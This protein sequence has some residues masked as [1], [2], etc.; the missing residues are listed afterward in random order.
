MRSPPTPANEAQR[1]EALRALNILDTA[2]EERFDRLTRLARRMFDV[3]VALVSL[4]D[5]NRQWFKS[6][7][8]IDATE[9]P[10]DVSFC[11]HAINSDQ[12]FE[13]QDARKD[14]RFS[15]N[16]LV[17]DNPNIRFYAACPVRS[18]TGETLGTL[19]IIDLKPR[20]L[21]ADERE[22]LRDLG[23]IVERELA[24]Q[25]M[26][27]IDELTGISNRSGFILLANKSLKYSARRYLSSSL[28]YLN[29]KKFKEINERGGRAEGDKT[30]IAIAE[31]MT[32]LF[33]DSD[34][35][36]RIGG[37]EFAAF[38]SDTDKEGAECFMRR[39]QVELD[40]YNSAEENTY[41]IEFS[42][43]IIEYDRFNHDTI[44]SVMDAAAKVMY[45]KKEHTAL[46]RLNSDGSRK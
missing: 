27:I 31:I 16:P 44:D 21:T 18:S 33:R 12:I 34:V 17:I 41:P 4:V 15:D 26:A 2:P 38:L 37:D 24:A 22:N 9:T 1:L 32:K 46:G 6:H 8:G 7:D 19:C 25:Q 28:V 20:S 13:I 42:Y 35:F 36:A 39:F 14:Q 29:V 43:C 5:K 11:G 40:R 30:L 3:P 45:W 23:L 10:R